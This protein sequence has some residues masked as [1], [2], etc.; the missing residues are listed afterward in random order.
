M[1]NQTI[2]NSS[3][4]HEIKQNYK[5]KKFKNKNPTD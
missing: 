4:L 3:Q 1:H 5:T 2:A